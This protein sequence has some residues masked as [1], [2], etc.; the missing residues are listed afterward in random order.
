MLLPR[1][2]REQTVTHSNIVR[3][4]ILQFVVSTAT[5]VDLK[6]PFRDV[7]PL[8]VEFVIPGKLPARRHFNRRAR[9]TNQE[10]EHEERSGHADWLTGCSTS[11]QA[12]KRGHPATMALFTIVEIALA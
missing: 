4:I 8:A 5:C 2:N 9:A 6:F 1:F 10:Q 11:F 12:S 7:E 3:D